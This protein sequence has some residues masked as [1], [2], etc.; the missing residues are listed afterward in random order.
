MLDQK[1][2]NVV[3]VLGRYESIVAPGIVSM[4]VRKRWLSV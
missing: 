1:P 3:A 4:T 2:G